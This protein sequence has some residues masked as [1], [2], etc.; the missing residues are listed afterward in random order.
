ML[1]V[2]DAGNPIRPAAGAIRPAPPRRTP[3]IDA[4]HDA[5]GRMTRGRDRMA[6]PMVTFP[7]R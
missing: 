2:D 7:G 5:L 4:W 6:V 1:S 3:T